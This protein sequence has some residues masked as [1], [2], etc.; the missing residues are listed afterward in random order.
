MDRKQLS[1]WRSEVISSFIAIEQLVN[2]IICQHYFERIDKNF[3]LEVL[4]DEY[5]D[6]GLR[7]RI[8]DKILPA[9]RKDLIQPLNR[10]SR[11]RNYFGHCGLEVIDGVGL[12]ALQEAGEVPYPGNPDRRIDFRELFDEFK[13]LEG[14]VVK[15]LAEFFTSLGGHCIL[16]DGQRIKVYMR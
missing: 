4:Y 15:P 1:E 7:R 12:P 10:M 3:F 5:F 9:D 13:D 8:L 6:F 14:R 16:D 11:I 2:C